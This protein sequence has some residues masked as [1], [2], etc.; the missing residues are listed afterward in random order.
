MKTISISFAAGTLLAAATMAQTPHYTVTDLGGVS[1]GSYSSANAIGNSGLTGGV[2]SL[3][4]GTQHAVLWFLGLGLKLDI[5][6]G[7]AGGPNSGVYGVNDRG[8]VL[9]GAEI[10]AKDPNNE[11]FC[12]YGTGLKCLAF[13]W[14]GGVTTQLATLGGN[15]ASVG[16]NVNNRGEMPGMAETATR[17]PLCPS[18]VASNGTGP[19]L[20]DY[21][22][23]IWGPGPGDI[24][25]LNPLP[26]DT[27]GMAFWIND[28]SQAVGASGTCANSSLPP[29]AFGAHAV[30]WA[31]D[32][33]VTSLGSL[34][35]TVNPALTGL[36]DIAFAI[37]NP[38]QAVG[39]ST[40]PSG[41]GGPSTANHAFLWTSGT[42]MKDLGTLPGDMVS[43]G[44][45][46][47][48]GGDV[49]GGSI[50]AEGNSRA[51]LWRSGT[52]SDLNTIS[53]GA[54]LFLL[55]AFGTNASGEIVGFG[56]TAKG[57]LH[58]F[59]AIPDVGPVTH[60]ATGPIVLSDEVRA[61]LRHRA[62]PGQFGNRVTA[63]PQP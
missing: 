12:G 34:G 36:G 59:L 29:F 3:P 10:T 33:S 30:L 27:V 55:A 13:L 6:K 38:G 1:G 40:I 7:G 16:N 44:L 48:D 18:G 15:N 14:Q 4:D 21:E 32:G 47:N 17:D 42:G 23:A 58:A 45:A 37:N 22:A 25:K 24:R 60:D 5:G 62:H 9:I 35:G 20:F 54:P 28:N 52:M 31:K 43:A 53:H 11:N 61:A 50:D 8:E 2:E 49:V 56:A 41:A 46:I 19:Q 39:T 26:G 57:D 63:P 51:F